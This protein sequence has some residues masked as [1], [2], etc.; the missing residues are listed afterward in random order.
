MTEDVNLSKAFP[1][2]STFFIGTV[3]H[4]L[5]DRFILGIAHNA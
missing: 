5:D 4:K 2:P 1:G 3:P